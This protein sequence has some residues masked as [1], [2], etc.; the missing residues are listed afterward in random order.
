MNQ[1]CNFADDTTFY[2]CGRDFNT[3]LAV[4]CF[5]NKFI[6]LNQEKRHLLISGQRNR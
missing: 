5:E 6:K 1:V 4:G 2:V 3:A